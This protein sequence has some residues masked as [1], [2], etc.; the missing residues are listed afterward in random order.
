MVWRRARPSAQ[1]GNPSLTEDQIIRDILTKYE[2]AVEKHIKDGTM[3]VKVAQDLKQQASYALNVAS[4]DLI[5]SRY[6]SLLSA[7]DRE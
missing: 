7:S 1:V 3:T 2:N 5:L 6:G 4:Q